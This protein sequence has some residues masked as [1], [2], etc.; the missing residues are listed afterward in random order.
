MLRLSDRTAPRGR[1]EGLATNRARWVQTPMLRADRCGSFGAGRNAD[2]APAHESPAALS[3]D[4]PACARQRGT[5]RARCREL[6]RTRRR[7]A[8]P[9]LHPAKVAGLT[10]T[11]QACSE[12]LGPAAPTRANRSAPTARA[13]FVRIGACRS[14]L[15]SP[16]NSPRPP[17]LTALLS[18]TSPSS[19]LSGRLAMPIAGAGQLARRGSDRPRAESIDRAPSRRGQDL[20]DGGLGRRPGI[21]AR[22]SMNT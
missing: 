5:D 20:A 14:L 12:P 15:P 18:P 7:S 8:L 9:V 19:R 21:R 6:R 22:Q 10:G 11:Q 17:P 4:G 1:G 3:F 16:T 13:A 2:T